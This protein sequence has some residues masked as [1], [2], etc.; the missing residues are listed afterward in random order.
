MPKFIT[1]GYGD[2][3]GYERTEDDRR[4][5][6]H[7]RDAEL[8]ANGALIARAG[9]PVQVRNHGDEGVQTTLGPFMQS[10]LPIAGFMVIDAADAQAA[11][12]LVAT[13]PCA[14]AYGVVEVWPLEMA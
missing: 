13:T 9:V 12:Q 2:Q 6:A 8:L 5:A 7:A 11:V 1:I 14:I 3:A 4:F 10:D